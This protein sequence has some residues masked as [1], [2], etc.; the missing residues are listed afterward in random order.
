[1][2]TPREIE[3]LLPRLWILWGPFLAAPWIIAGVSQLVPMQEGGLAELRLVLFG[4]SCLLAVGSV[5]ASFFLATRLRE[6]AFARGVAP[7]GAITSSFVVANALCE[8]G[9]IAA[10]TFFLMT[11][12]LP[13]LGL[14][15]LGTAGA[16][17]HRPSR[18][19]LRDWFEQARRAAPRPPPSGGSL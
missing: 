11:H 1:V 12:W 3:N 9:G 7:T 10:A 14:I 18:D 17:L 5:G 4:I 2:E 19:S 15:V 8:A 16:V 13:F 6:Q